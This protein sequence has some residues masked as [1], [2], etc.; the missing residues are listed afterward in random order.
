MFHAP[1]HGADVSV[2]RKVLY[3]QDGLE[4]LA[5]VGVLDFLRCPVPQR[6]DVPLKVTRES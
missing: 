1:N 3:V 4:I 2:C 6:R 5:P